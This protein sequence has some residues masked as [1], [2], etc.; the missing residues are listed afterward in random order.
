MEFMKKMLCALG[1]SLA[2]SASASVPLDSLF[3]AAPSHV[4]PL[5]GLNERLNLLDLYDAGHTALADNRLGGTAQLVYKDSARLVL[6]VCPESR[7][8]LVRVDSATLVCL[9]TVYLPA[10]DT[11]VEV[12]DAH[13]RRLDCSV[14]R[15]VADDFLL[16]ADSVGG[17][18]RYELP[19]L[20]RP[21]HVKWDWESGERAFLLTIS[22]GGLPAAEAGE[23]GAM[24][25]PLRYVW[26]DAAFRRA[27]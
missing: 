19:P 24:L 14:P 6:D 18:R 9:R 15:P 7:F 4:L 26:A 8:E 21:L 23:L 12:Y 11:Q 10:A 22:T 25:R 1:L 17:D 3:V 16:H 13:W 27:D 20:L 5:L 2:F